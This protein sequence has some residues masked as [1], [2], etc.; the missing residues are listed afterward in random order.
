MERPSNLKARAATWSNYKHHNTVKVLLGITPQS[1]ISFVS[2]SWGGRVSD[3]YLTENCGILRKLLPGDIL[4]ADRGFDIRESVGVMQALLHVPA[5]MKGKKHLSALKVDETRST[6]NVRIHIE[7][8][9]GCVW[10]RFSILQS[11]I[12]IH[13][14]TIRKDK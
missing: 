7:C 2:D 10:Q 8:V 1:V 12:P 6:A 3:K 9:I 11:T 14:L 5:F 4:L 13:F